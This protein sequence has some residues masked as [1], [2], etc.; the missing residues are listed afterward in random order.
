MT[1]GANGH[2]P[3]LRVNLSGRIFGRLLVESFAGRDSK[4]R[5][6]WLCQCVCGS[7]QIVNGSNLVRGL[8]RSCGCFRAEVS[9][10]RKIT[11]GQAGR[12]KRSPEYAAWSQM[13]TRCYNPNT[14]GYA[15][16][17]G[18]GI[19][20]CDRWHSFESFLQDMGPKP[21]S[22]HSLD[23]W[24][25]NDGNYQPGNCRWATLSQQA[26]NKSNTWIVVFRGETLPLVE[27]CE[28]MGLR[29]ATVKQ[30]IKKGWSVDL[31]LTTPVL[32]PRG[33]QLLVHHL[34]GDAA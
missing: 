25:D 20:V 13:H 3:G 21:S 1:A 2:I 16:Y 4:G 14:I 5:A 7:S 9:A 33:V 32:P 29:A 10:E 6:E 27:F 18:R 26:R 11:H 19:V 8:S 30:R 28:R 31:A 15:Q 23:R 34:A 12:G 24:P 17:G 22:K